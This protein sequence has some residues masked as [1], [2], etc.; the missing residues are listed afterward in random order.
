MR[1]RLRLYYA[2]L[3]LDPT[4]I[5]TSSKDLTVYVI[6]SQ[7][8]AEITNQ[9]AEGAKQTFLEAGGNEEQLKFIPVTGAWELP[10][11]AATLS[12]DENIDAIVTLGC[13]ITG[14]TTHDQVIAHAIAQGLMQLSITWGKPIS[15]GILTCK[16]FEQA[17]ERAGGTAGNKGA[18][19]MNAAISTHHVISN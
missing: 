5:S 14:E 7:Y 17:K 19:A 18:E 10:V 15:M 8:H 1:F 9:L 2:H 6:V 11:V 4:H 13:I 3:M 12:E 16:T